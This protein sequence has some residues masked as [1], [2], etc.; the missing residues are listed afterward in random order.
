MLEELQAHTGAGG[1]GEPRLEELQ[2]LSSF[3]VL[4]KKIG[5]LLSQVN[6]PE[7]FKLPASEPSPHLSQEM[8][9]DLGVV[10]LD[11]YY[12]QALDD[13][14][15]D[16]YLAKGGTKTEHVFPLGPENIQVVTRA[17]DV[18]N[19][20]LINEARDMKQSWPEDRPGL[21]EQLRILY[22]L[23]AGLKESR[24][25]LDGVAEAW[26]RLQ[27]ETKKWPEEV[28]EFWS[29][30][31]KLEFVVDPLVKQVREAHGGDYGQGKSYRELTQMVMDLKT[32]ADACGKTVRDRA[33]WLEK[34]EAILSELSL[35]VAQAIQGDES[36]TD[37]GVVSLRLSERLT[38]LEK[39]ELWL[40]N[41]V[42]AFG[43]CLSLCPVF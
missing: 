15:R 20:R 34:L 18:E 6:F 28:K 25:A 1:T 39:E 13:S 16:K 26:L 21:D 24:A 3:L 31:K 36:G 5:L 41:Q 22:D 19:S 9:G 14:L 27:G 33:Q 32:E 29:K 38:A 42:I 30:T 17:L 23:L 7:S 12:A 43:Y 35:L 11:D 37:W 10:S 4:A 40:K 2:D 8:I